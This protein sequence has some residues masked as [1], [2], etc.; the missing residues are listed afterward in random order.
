MREENKKIIIGRW[1]NKAQEDELSAQSILAH[2]D[3]APSVVCF[4]SQQ[5]AEKCL[6]SLVIF[7]D[8]ELEKV[9]DLIK[10]YSLVENKIPEM[11][12]IKEELKLLNRYYIETR[13]VG[14]YPEFS[15]NDAGKAFESAIKIKNFVLDKIK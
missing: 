10:L 3:G 9:H 8:M 6:K 13:Y 1:F 14:D 2:R 4:L 5:I 11:A 15:W 12:D 7:F